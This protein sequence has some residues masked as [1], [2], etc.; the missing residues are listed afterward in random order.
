MKI[1]TIHVAILVV[2]V[3]SLPAMLQAQMAI[4][5]PLA[6]VDIP[7]PFSAGGVHLPAG[8]YRIS[9][10]GDPYFVLIEKDDGSARALVYVQPSGVN[11]SESSKLVFNKYG[12]RYFLS[13]LWT[14]PD[15]RVHQCAKDRQEKELMAQAQKAEPVVVAA[16]R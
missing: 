6:R 12:N 15:Q 10:P 9:H 8:Q 14:E 5:E 3:L 13:Q 1:R 2:L 4:K 16:K 7:F 11:S